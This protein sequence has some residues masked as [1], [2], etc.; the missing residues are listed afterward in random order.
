MAEPTL[1]QRLLQEIELDDEDNHGGFR[2]RSIDAVRA[3]VELHAPF[4]VNGTH[5]EGGAPWVACKACQYVEYPC[6]TIR[7]IAEQLG[8]AVD[9]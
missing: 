7:A 9:G 4:G 2:C 3:V 6:K 5:Q 8:V 1:H